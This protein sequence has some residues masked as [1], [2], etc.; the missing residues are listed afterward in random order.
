MNHP[1]VYQIRNIINNKVY[2]GSAVSFNRR[3]SAHLYH[4]R[5]G[6]H[7]SNHLQYSWNKYGESNFIFEILDFIGDKNIMEQEQYYLDKIKS[8]DDMNIGYNISKTAN[9]CPSN[10]KDSSSVKRGKDHPMFGKKH[11]KET[12]TKISNSRIGSKNP[13]YGKS[14]WNKGLT[15]GLSCL[16]VMIDQFDLDNNF[17]KT[18]SSL[19]EI[20]NTLGYSQGN[21]CSCCK[22][23]RPRANG[24]KWRY[25]EL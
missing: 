15:E 4:L 2:I 6:S 19:S 20:H 22:A 17:I 25:N 9:Y 5:M 14:T 8:Y 11:S 12:I 18:W 13:N 21:I 7:H 3:R 24:Y 16:S 23:Q 1:V 10:K